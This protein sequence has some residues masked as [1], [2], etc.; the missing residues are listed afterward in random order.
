MSAEEPMPAAEPAPALAGDFSA[1]AEKVAKKVKNDPNTASKIDNIVTG[2]VNISEEIDD[3]RK[4]NLFMN[5]DIEKQISNMR[6]VFNE[7]YDSTRK[8]VNRIESQI[9]NFPT[10]EELSAVERSLNLKF[11]NFEANMSHRFESM[12]HRFD[13]MADRFDSIEK[14]IEILSSKLSRPDVA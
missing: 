7:K 11:E 6:D 13:S 5:K 1:V 3:F 12:N 4:T 10:R 9:S 2:I 8:S 14:Q